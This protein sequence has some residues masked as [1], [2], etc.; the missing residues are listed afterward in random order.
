ML[1][2]GLQLSE[3]LLAVDPDMRV[4]WGL[5]MRPPSL[6][7]VVL[8]SKD[9]SA[10]PLKEPFKATCASGTVVTIVLLLA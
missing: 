6:V 8:L 2:F 7:N 10:A 4:P 5:G 1:P 3:A 9:C